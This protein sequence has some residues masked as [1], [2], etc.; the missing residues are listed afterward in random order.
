LRFDFVGKSS[1]RQVHEIEDRHVAKLV[2]ELLRHRGEVFKFRNGGGVISDVK[3]R[4]INDYIHER[5]GDRFTAKDF[6]TWAGSLL[7]ACVLA[8]LPAES[9]QSPTACRRAIAGAMREVAKQLGNTPAVCRKSYVFPVVLRRF[10][11]GRVLEQPVVGIPKTAVVL[12][13]VERGL[14]ALLEPTP[15]ASQAAV[16]RRAA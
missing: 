9:W 15:R 5:M 11:E 4:H 7:A 13:R 1:R 8:R 16:L 12:E 10:E 14:L 6:R 3:G 2:R